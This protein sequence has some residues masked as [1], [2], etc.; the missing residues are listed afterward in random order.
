MLSFLAVM[1]GQ[2]RIQIF[3]FQAMQYRIVNES[4]RHIRHPLQ[5]IFQLS[6]LCLLSRNRLCRSGEALRFRNA[7]EPV[8][9]GRDGGFSDFVGVDYRRLVCER[10]ARG[11]EIQDRFRRFADGI[12]GQL[13]VDRPIS[14]EVGDC[15]QFFGS[16]GARHVSLYPS[17]R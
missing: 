9:I 3:A 4:S 8:S 10:L 16:E 5:L 2:R 13:F 7:R 14:N 11:D 1:L 15:F 17:F 6:N 12:P